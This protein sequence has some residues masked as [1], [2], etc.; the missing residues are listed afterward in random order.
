MSFLAKIGRSPRIWAMV[1]GAVLGGLLFSQI[2]LTGSVFGIFFGGVTGWFVGAFIGAL[3]GLSAV[4]D[5]R[6]LLERRHGDK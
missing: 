2:G 4:P 1:V 3:I 5:L 6:S